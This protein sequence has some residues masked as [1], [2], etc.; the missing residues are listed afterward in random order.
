MKNAIG[1]F[2]L[3]GVLAMNQGCAETKETPKSAQAMKISGIDETMQ[4]FVD[5]G[6]LSGAVMTVA[7]DKS[8][9][10]LSAIGQ[11]DLAN[12]LPMQTDSMFWIAS[13]T[14]PMTSTAIMMLQED[15]KLSVDDPVSKYIP[16]FANLKTPSG[17]PANLTLHHLLT[18]TSGMVEAPP[19]VMHSA[20]TL[21]D[22]IPSYLDHPTNF[23]PGTKWQYCQS[24]IN[25]LGRII[26][27]VSGQP[28]ADFMQ[29]HIIRPM[30]LKDTTYYPTPEQIGRLAV[31]YNLKDGVLS[32]T[33]IT[34]LPGPVGDHNHYAAPNGGLFS[35]AG[36]YTRF[37]QMLLNGGILD[38]RRFLQQQSVA[39]MTRMQTEGV[40]EVGFIP[41]SAWG[42]ALGIVREPQGM[43]AMLSAG[44]F[45]HGGAYGT[46]AWIDPVKDRIYILMFQRADI[47][48]SDNSKYRLAFQQ[49][50][51]RKLAD[52]HPE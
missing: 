28:Y 2:L 42:L 10:H 24:G 46:E 12:H 14:K 30:G 43:T 15:G 7:D 38:G 17:K 31:S 39:E 44:T 29:S 47:G 37:C 5:D 25:T 3:T 8:V 11:R 40:P 36:D 1:L 22:L 50:A 23:E 33:A 49:A 21:T 4:P 32:P 52:G 45:G 48:N 13:M 6:E 34:I 41:G 27:I 35:T 18:H 9:L 19:E 26:E 16:E 20:R 51:T